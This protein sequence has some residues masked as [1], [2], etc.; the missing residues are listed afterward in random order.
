M[1][2]TTLEEK[3]KELDALKEEF[4]EYI[5]SSRD[6]EGELE[7]EVAKLAEEKSDAESRAILLAGQLAKCQLQTSSLESKLTS[8]TKDLSSENQRRVAAETRTEEAENKMREAEGSLKQLK[9]E[10]EESLERFA[11]VE[12]EAEDCRNELNA[13]KQRYREEI[14]A[15]RTDV[16]VLR[17]KLKKKGIL[18]SDGGG[19]KGNGTHIIQPLDPGEAVSSKPTDEILDVPG[20]E[21]AGDTDSYDGTEKDCAKQA[22][23]DAL[24]TAFDEYIASSRELEEE[25]DAELTKCQDELTSAESRNTA[26]ASQLANIQPQLT[27]LETK[28]SS[29]T[30]Q[31]SAESQ[32][33]IA[34][35]MKSEEAENKLREAEGALA[36]VRSSEVRKL[37]EENEDLC[38]RLAFVE[39]EA[40][41][42]RNELN[43]ERE[44]HREE[45]EEVRGD[46]NVLTA[47]LKERESESDQEKGGQDSDAAGAVKEGSGEDVESV[48]AENDAK[49]ASPPPTAETEPTGASNE[50]REEYIRTL[51]EELELVTEQLIEAETKLSQ[52]QSELEEALVEAEEATQALEKGAANEGAVDANSGQPDKVAELETSVK[53]L[54]E[55]NAALQDESKRLKEELEL[56]LEELALSKEE[57]EA[58]EEDRKDQSAGFDAE[59]KQHKEEVASLQTQLNEV[60]SKERTRDIESKSWEA[61]LVA[62][63]KEAQ[64]LTEEV[65][66]LEVALKD[67]KAD[68]ETLQGEMD[69]LKAAYDETA[70]REKAE[71]EGQHQA[72]EELL[73]TRKREV[74][75]LKEEVA[76]LT[77]T[78]SSLTGM[79]KELEGNLTKQQS[80]IEMQQK[81]VASASASSSEELQDAR[82][83]I[84]SLEGSLEAAR[85][86]LEEQRN[87]V[88]KVRSSLEEKIAHAQK[89]LTTAE[90]ELSRT[91]LKLQ[92]AEKER[93][94]ASVLAE[95]TKKKIVESEGD[96][97]QQAATTSSLQEEITRLENQN[98][99]SLSMKSHL[100]EEVKQLRKELLDAKEGPQTNEEEKK[101][102]DIDLV[103][104]DNTDDVIRSNDLETIAKEYQLVAKKAAGLKAHNA[105]LLTRILKLQ[106]N[107]QVCCRIRPMSAE[108]SQENLHEVTQAL[109]EAEVGCFD[110]RTR[111]WKSYAFDKVWGPETQNKDVF[112]DVEPLALSVCD[113]YNACIFAYGQTGS[114]KT[115]TMEGS[116]KSNTGISQRTIQK[117][118]SL[119]NDRALQQPGFE[120]TIQVALLEIYNDEVY[121][122]LDPNFSS[123]SIG[124]KKLD[125]RHGE[126]D[127]VQVAGLVKEKAGSIPEVLVA[128]ERGNS[129]RAKAST[130]LNEHSSRSH[131][132]LQV[133]VTSGVG[134]AKNKG[135]L[136]LVDL[137]GSERTK[138][139]EAG[140]QTMKEAQHINKSLSA[141]GNVMEALDRK[142]SHVPYRD[143]KLTHLLQ[144]SLGGNSRTM[145][146][147]TVCP[148]SYDETVCT[149]KF[150]TRVR[151]INLGSAQRNIASKNLEET[152]KQLTSEVSTLSKAKERSESQMHTL[153]REKARVE[154]RLS[155][156]AISRQN[157]KEE[158]R[159]LSVL[160]QSNNDIT[161][162]W[163]KEKNAREEK[164]TELGKVQEELQKVQRDLRTVKRQQETLAQQNDDKENTI[165][166]L[167]KDLRTMKEQLNE[168]KIRLRRSQVMQSRIP[169]PTK[170][171]RSAIKANASARKPLTSTKPSGLATPTRIKSTAAS[172]T[173]ADD[174]PNSVA[175]IRYRVLKMFKEHDPTKVDKLDLVM[176][177]FKGREA[178]LLDK[179][180][181]RFERKE[182]TESI[183]SP[184]E[185]ESTTAPP[186]DVRPKSRQDLALERHMA[187]MKRIRAASSKK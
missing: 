30:T 166:K 110:E 143:S 117:I 41:D 69:V 10:L 33:R 85:T 175:R 18:R 153:K 137:A 178:E 114:G 156:A 109:G 126:D 44:R 88:C 74:D 97:E 68:C 58:Y 134:E 107:I 51:E 142:S 133:E 61:E 8:I 118:F 62:S 183:T 145:M 92:E 187:R 167:K 105:Q 32:R 108:E 48:F 104:S 70:T 9:E 112:G 53:Q 163:Q 113:G 5:A 91:H 75:E 21:E 146:V 38:E 65:G 98:R 15:L 11:F 83:A 37:K 57:L 52:T 77:E 181:A 43:T 164:A 60:S 20:S 12:G 123:G 89:E 2:A 165:F 42:Y 154:E 55:E 182:T 40:E 106:G 45:L 140:G 76:N 17:G 87:E 147:V 132:V 4:D 103:V 121:D 64:S 84:S 149:L 56:A 23:L 81:H 46:V 19:G 7:E 173:K 36:A 13:E 100:E 99:M 184:V 174:D 22:E 168:E 155:K 177:K 6:M 119:L 1:T 120:F 157:S 125:M 136:S 90:E 169:A 71:S 39:G 139:S 160:R 16:E 144:N 111:S 150:G 86:E 24:Q 50:E 34:A 186:E 159:T 180:I 63:K 27:S 138:K 176:E 59:R 161:A 135:I 28:L 124:K 78:N 101:D 66:R 141:L 170:G 67:S 152:V 96:A 102:S 31:L 185:A 26:L 171:T 79:L 54:Q 3:Q 93:A 148:H 158:T 162:R 172:A 122:L 47:R 94:A 14:R 115:F 116:S 128:L 131:M 130:N 29:V 95:E 151:K 129:N 127:T 82:D 35:E 49:A 72:L 73:A 25:L 179:M 80:E